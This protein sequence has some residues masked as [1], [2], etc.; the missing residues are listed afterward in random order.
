MTI[1]NL[2]NDG[3]CKLVRMG[4][5]RHPSHIDE[6]KP[7]HLTVTLSYLFALTY[8]TTIA[9]IIGIH[10]VGGMSTVIFDGEGKWIDFKNW[11]TMVVTLVIPIGVAIGL[12]YYS[13]KQNQ[14]MHKESSEQQTKISNLTNEIHNFTIEESMVRKEIQQDISYH[15]DSKLD[16]IIRTLTHSLKMHKNYQEDKN[17]KKDNWLLAMKDSYDRC[18]SLLDF[19]LNLLQMMKI[20]G[21]SPAR[22]Y[23]RLLGKLQLKSKF[24]YDILSYDFTDFSKHIEECLEEG[25]TLKEVI[26]PFLPKKTSKD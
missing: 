2:C 20:F 4:L 17:G 23:W 6:E 3:M 24:W 15:M 9:I 14:I 1:E 5:D 13:N 10:F 12:W 7:T 26:K 19:Q 8:G 18:Y 22:K 11:V 21:T 25:K 16:L